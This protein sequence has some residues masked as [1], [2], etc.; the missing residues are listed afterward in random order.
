MSVVIPWKTRKAD[1]PGGDDRAWP[2]PLEEER[3]A[4]ADDDHRRHD[5]GERRE[6]EDDARPR[7]EPPPEPRVPRDESEV[8][9]GERERP[10]ERELAGERRL[11]VR[12]EDREALHE[13]VHGAG[14][15]RHPCNRPSEAEQPREPVGRRGE[16][17]E[18]DDGDEL[19][20]DAVG[21][22]HVEQHGHERRDR[23]I[24]V[25]RRKPCVPGG[26]PTEEPAR[27]QQHVLEHL[28]KEHVGAHVPP[29]GRVRDE[30]L[31]E[32]DERARP[33]DAEEPRHDE[34]DQQ[35]RRPD[36]DGDH[37]S[38]HSG[39]ARGDRRRGVEVVGRRCGRG[40]H[41]IEARAWP[42]VRPLPILAGDVD[43]CIELEVLPVAIPPLGLA[44]VA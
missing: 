16:R 29:G 34:D 32:P 43:E 15:G 20:G 10:G 6:R 30:D 44:P 11:D 38:G 17:D 7:G 4:G 14:E 37:P 19:E 22:E 25:E 5:V 26:R 21:Q 3:D 33:D 31:G 27:R 12:P 28:G 13:H 9:E 24:E 18:P 41:R 1:D 40:C 39:V 2:V 36:E 42:R 8:E 23:E 35:R